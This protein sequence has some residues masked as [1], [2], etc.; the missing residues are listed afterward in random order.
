MGEDVLQRVLQGNR[1]GD[2]YAVL[3]VQPEIGGDE[4][5]AQERLRRFL[6]VKGLPTEATSICIK[7]ILSFLLPLQKNCIKI[8]ILHWTTKGDVAVPWGV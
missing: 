6:V 2:H 4:V 3:G 7:S 8:V 5:S 1:R